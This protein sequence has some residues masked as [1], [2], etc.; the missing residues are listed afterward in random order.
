MSQGTHTAPYHHPYL[1]P[2]LIVI[3]SATIAD[4][5]G[6]PFLL[7]IF[8]KILSTF[9]EEPLLPY[10][11][12]YTIRLATGFSVSVTESFPYS[13]EIFLHCPSELFRLVP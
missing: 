11:N 1:L 3:R 9:R 2:F 10:P 13:S 5:S 6:I 7:G 8:P 4:S 12:F